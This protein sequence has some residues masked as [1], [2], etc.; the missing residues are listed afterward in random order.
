MDAELSTPLATKKIGKLLPKTVRDALPPLGSTSGEKDPLV[1]AK[2]FTPDGGWTWYAIEFDGQD[3]FYGLVE[4]LETEFGYFSL[5]ELLEVRGGL[6]LPVERDRYFEPRR[7][8]EISIR[9]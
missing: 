3:T 8:S 9:T 4:G 5:G 1:V 6:G 2:F 7:L